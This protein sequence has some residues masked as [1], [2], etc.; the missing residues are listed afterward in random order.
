MAV[1]GVAPP[2]VRGCRL[3]L[4]VCGGSRRPGFSLHD[5]HSIVIPD[6]R[7]PSEV[8]LVWQSGRRPVVSARWHR[9]WRPPRPVGVSPQ[10][11]LRRKRR[12]RSHWR[13]ARQCLRLLARHCLLLSQPGAGSLG[14]AAPRCCQPSRPTGTAVF[15]PRRRGWGVRCC[16]C[17]RRERLVLLSLPLWPRRPHPRLVRELTQRHLLLA[18]VIRVSFLDRGGRWHLCCPSPLIPKPAVIPQFITGS[19]YRSLGTC[20]EQF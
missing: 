19:T 15:T 1:F 5:N 16:S 3:L 13:R 20:P 6:F 17:R 14:L 11:F 9:G 10:C 2:L 4:G 12:H 18:R 8:A 7:V